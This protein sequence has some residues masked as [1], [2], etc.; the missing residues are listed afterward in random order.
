MYW[1]KLYIGE[2]PLSLFDFIDWLGSCWG[3]EFFFVPLVIFW[4]LLVT[5]VYVLCTL[6]CLFGTLLLLL[7][8]FIY[9]WYLVHYLD[10]ESVTIFLVCWLK[11]HGIHP[12]IPKSSLPLSLT[13]FPGSVLFHI[14]YSCFSLFFHDLSYFILHWAH[15]AKYHLVGSFLFNF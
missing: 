15:A 10:V 8:A 4:C 1:T 7:F 12:Q 9:K 11:M 6:V 13:I 14:T 3:N 2:G 5:I